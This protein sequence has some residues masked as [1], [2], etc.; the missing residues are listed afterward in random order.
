MAIITCLGRLLRQSISWVLCGA[1]PYASSLLEAVVLHASSLLK[2]IDSMI[3]H[4]SS[5]LEAV[6]SMIRLVAT[7]LLEATGCIDACSM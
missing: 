4:A 1:Y 5:L 3:V 6:D 2:A 7:G